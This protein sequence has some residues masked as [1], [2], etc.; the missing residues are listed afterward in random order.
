M[1][2]STNYG[3]RGSALRNN[4]NKHRL[5]MAGSKTGPAFFMSPSRISCP[6]RGRIFSRHEM[7]NDIQ[8]NRAAG[9][10]VKMMHHEIPLFLIA[11]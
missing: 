4:G 9:R 7:E 5:D 6:A 10:A 2:A 8:S 1:A 3:V 11:R